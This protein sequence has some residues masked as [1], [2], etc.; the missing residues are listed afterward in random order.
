VRFCPTKPGRWKL[1]EVSA[2]N[3][4]LK[5][6]QEGHYVT[7][8]SSAGGGF[9][10]VDADSPGRRWY[11]RS[12]GPGEYIIGNTHYT[13]LS[14]MTGRGPSGSDI[15]ADVAGNAEY[16]KKLRFSL[17]PDRYPHPKDKPFFDAAFAA[18]ASDSALG[19]AEFS[20]DFGFVIC[21]RRLI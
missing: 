15:A 8:T 11:K 1:I 5:G 4:E 6:K 9:W 12:G 16:F 7:A 14:G 21:H 10:E 2:D 3:A 20:A 18:L 19:L 17:V 13:F